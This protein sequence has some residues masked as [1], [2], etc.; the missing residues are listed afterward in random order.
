MLCSALAQLDSELFRLGRIEQSVQQRQARGRKPSHQDLAALLPLG[1]M[2]TV[3]RELGQAWEHVC[4]LEEEALLALLGEAPNDA[5]TAAQRLTG[6]QVDAARAWFLA[7]L[8]F[9]GLQFESPNRA[10]LMLSGFDVKSLHRLAEAY[11]QVLGAWADTQVRL[12]QVTM[13]GRGQPPKLEA[14]KRVEA[15]FAAHDPETTAVLFELEGP[16]VL[17]RLVSESGVHRLQRD[18]QWH[19]GEVHCIDKPL[20]DIAL[21]GP[22]RVKPAAKSSRRDYQL[23]ARLV[24]DTVTGGQYRFGGRRLADA[25]A[26]AQ[27]ASVRR[28]IASLIC[29]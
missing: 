15:F 16:H 4:A 26:L 22:A 14:V 19:E 13:G 1:R 3:R 7:M 17:S 5:G 12:H 27:E 24:Q 29:E 20:A 23:D 21:P 6:A 8:G 28:A 11:H 2:R 9:F 25:L 18:G 10:V